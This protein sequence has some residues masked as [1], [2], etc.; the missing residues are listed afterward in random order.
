MSEQSQ[1]ESWQ[2]M[3]TAYTM[4]EGMDYT[5]AVVRA[6]NG[7]EVRIRVGGM[8]TEPEHEAFLIDEAKLQMPKKPINGAGAGMH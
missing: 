4:R 7:I 1:T 8:K 6:P 2:V 3:R 5:D